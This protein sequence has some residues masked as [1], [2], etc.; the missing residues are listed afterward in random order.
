MSCFF[1]TYF[2][3]CSMRVRRLR[4][5]AERRAAVA[6]AFQPY[7]PRYSVQNGPLIK[8][9]KGGNKSIA[10]GNVRRGQK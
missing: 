8:V 5:L 9:D 2:W 4:I 3:V 6:S 7:R 1:A 10:D